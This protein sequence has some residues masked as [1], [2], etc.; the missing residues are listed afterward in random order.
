MRK[1]LATIILIWPLLAFCNQNDVL[2]AIT[3]GAEYTHMTKTLMIQIA[4][5]ESTFNPNAKNRLSGA[6]GL[7]QVVDNTWDYLVATYGEAYKLTPEGRTDAYIATVGAGLLLREY[8][9]RL[10]RVLHRPVTNKEV[11]LAY[12]AG[13]GTAIHLLS[14]DSSTDIEDVLNSASIR[15]N[16]DLRGLSVG[17]AI[18]VITRGIDNE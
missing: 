17:E 14:A 11:Y 4:K 6:T 18:S 16:P 3:D 9:T 5:K 2:S 7:F 12:F 15:A 8:R 10:E 13:P 1:L